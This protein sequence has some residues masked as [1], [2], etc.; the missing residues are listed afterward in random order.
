MGREVTAT[1]RGGEAGRRWWP[2]EGGGDLRRGGAAVPFPGGAMR[3]RDFLLRKRVNPSSS[4][5]AARGG[6]EGAGRAGEAGEFGPGCLA[7]GVVVT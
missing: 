2:A 4:T 7:A 6:R 3:E 5:T 1:G